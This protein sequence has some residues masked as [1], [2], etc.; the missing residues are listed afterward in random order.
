MHYLMLEKADREALLATLE[1]M[2]DYLAT[3]FETF[4]T[5]SHAEVRFPGPG[6]VLS[7]V[8]QS[9][10]LADLEREGFAV[11]IRRLLDEADPHL[12][13][14]DGGRIARERAYRSLSLDEGLAAFREARLRNLSMLRAVSPEDWGRRGTQEG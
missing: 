7:P 11:R 8:E 2:P 13:D 9:W 5:L 1:S 6:E 3:T 10:H 4:E 14:F 12:P